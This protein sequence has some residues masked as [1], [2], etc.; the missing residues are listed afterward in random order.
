MTADDGRATVITLIDVNLRVKALAPEV[1]MP[2]QLAR[3]GETLSGLL[4]R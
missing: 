4:T 2:E 3:V 1:F